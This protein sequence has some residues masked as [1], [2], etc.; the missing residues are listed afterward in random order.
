[1]ELIYLIFPFRTCFKEPN[2]SLLYEVYFI[3][4]TRGLM[5]LVN[6][7]NSKVLRDLRVAT[8]MPLNLL[9]DN[10]LPLQVTKKVTFWFFLNTNLSESAQR[11]VSNLN[12]AQTSIGING[13]LY[14]SKVHR[15]Y[16]ES[17]I[18]DLDLLPKDWN[19]SLKIWRTQVH[20]VDATDSPV[21]DFYWRLSWVCSSLDWLSRFLWGKKISYSKNVWIGSKSKDNWNV[22]KHETTWNITWTIL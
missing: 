6:T 4:L 19:Y 13:E 20:L 18:K 21:F 16:I 17:K 10:L 3:Q 15:K 11:T 14:M 2:T 8:L 22:S 12:A 5:H 1:M 7:S 9:S